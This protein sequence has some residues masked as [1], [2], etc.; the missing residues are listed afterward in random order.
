[1]RT[2]LYR[3][4]MVSV[5]L[6]SLL[7]A[8]LGSYTNNYREVRRIQISIDL[9]KNQTYHLTESIA[10]K[11]YN[12]LYKDGVPISVQFFDPYGI[13]KAETLNL[14]FEKIKKRYFDWEIIKNNIE[15]IQRKSKSSKDSIAL[16]SDSNVIDKRIADSSGTNDIYKVDILK[17]AIQ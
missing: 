17:L 14:K 16:S 7:E 2:A 8:I 5:L 11:Y 4:P 9:T 3:D 13:S 10:S 15:K 1:M 6:Q 12:I